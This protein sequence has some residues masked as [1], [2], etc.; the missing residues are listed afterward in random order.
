MHLKT[1]ILFADLGITIP[2]G[3]YT[4]KIMSDCSLDI[5][6]QRE[7]YRTTEFDLVDHLT[8]A[9]SVHHISDHRNEAMLHFTRYL[10]IIDFFSDT[11][12]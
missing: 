11:S 12:L 7:M 8:V 1:G 9:H 10:F 5:L 6:T 2:H 4:M 3:Q